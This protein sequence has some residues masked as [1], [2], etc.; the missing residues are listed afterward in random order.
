MLD[1]AFLL[2]QQAAA[3]R[4]RNI[5]V[6]PETELVYATDA[7]VR[8]FDA[9]VEELTEDGGLILE[10]TAFYPTGGGQPHD[11]GVLTWSEIKKRISPKIYYRAQTGMISLENTH[12]M[13][14]G[15]V[16]PQNTA[17][18][19]PYTA[20]ARWRWARARGPF[21]HAQCPGHCGLWQSL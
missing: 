4:P 1:R 11:V 13:A 16:Y 20:P 15:T 7:Y 8:S 6:V 21:W 19:H 14:G 2:E 3:L 10:R 12:N 9:H 17:P 5:S 18:T